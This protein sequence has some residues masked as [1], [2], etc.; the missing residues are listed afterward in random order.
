M[1]NLSMAGASAG[2]A[3]VSDLDILD[4]SF[5]IDPHPQVAALRRLGR[6]VFLEKTGVWAVPR[7]ADV[8]AV[9][10]DHDTFINS[11][12]VGLH[13][14]I[15]EPPPRA[16]SLLLEADPPLHTRTRAIIQKIMSGPAIRKLRETIFEKAEALIEPLVEKGEFDAI[17]E[18]AEVFPPTVL[19]E[20][21]GLRLGTD[22][23]DKLVRYGL[24]T[25]AFF[26]PRN[27][28]FEEI[29]ATAKDV[30]PW[31]ADQCQR[32]SLSPDGFGAQVYAA[33]DDGKLSADEAPLLVR[34]FLA[35]GLDTSIAGIGRVIHCLATHPDQWQLLSENPELARS[36]FEEMMRFDHPSIGVFRTA[37]RDCEF[38]GVAIPKHEKVFALTGSANRDPEQWNDPDTYDIRRVT[39]GHLGFGSG[40]HVCAGMMVI[41]LEAEA[42]LRAL[43]RRVAR[44]ELSGTPTYRSRAAFRR[45]FA[46]LSIRITRK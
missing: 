24:L 33:M 26:G 8:K 22:G 16:P 5:S 25:F 36:A 38:A 35:A 13:N 29:M 17:S 18:I 10:E 31:I 19:P 23:R 7:Y 1:G 11:G 2:G 4:P 42:I 9:L 27:E 6:A 37:S 28:Y 34:S 3:P 30:L 39:V 21:V 15:K 43:A 40:I 20:A 12:G 45:A 41:R 46:T 32:A 44:L 14:N